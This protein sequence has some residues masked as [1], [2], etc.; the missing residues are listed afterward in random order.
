MSF[1]ILRGFIA[2]LAG[3]LA[4]LA[5]IALFFGPAQRILTNPALQS[6][7]MLAVF[8]S[9][10]APR[11]AGAPW[12]LAAGLLVIGVLWGWVYVWVSGPWPGAWWRRGLR[13][14]VVSWVLMV[15]WFE[16]YLPWNVLWEP[17][18]LVTLEMMCWAGVLTGVGL[19]I[20]GVDAALRPGHELVA[21]PRWP[22]GQAT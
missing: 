13:F 1:P 5:G 14:G 18:P 7:K 22:A 19:T 12:L 16:F 10:P 21:S 4:W 2:G 9:E 8:T 15:P 6:A 20:A 3:G 11:S 17:A